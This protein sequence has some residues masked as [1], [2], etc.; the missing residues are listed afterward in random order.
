MTCNLSVLVAI[1]I[2]MLFWWKRPCH[3]PLSSQNPTWCLAIN[4]ANDSSEYHMRSTPRAQTSVSPSLRSPDTQCYQS[5]LLPCPT[6]PEYVMK[7]RSY[8]I[9]RHEFPYDFPWKQQQQNNNNKKTKINKQTKNRENSISLWWPGIST[10]CVH[11]P[12][13]FPL[14]HVGTYPEIFMNVHLPLFP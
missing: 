6:H 1:S 13:E 7:F 14:W 4:T 5:L 2:T 12:P 8:G 10:T 3:G 9:Y 11:S